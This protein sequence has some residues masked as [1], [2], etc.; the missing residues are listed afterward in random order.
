MG[1]CID[2]GVRPPYIIF[3]IQI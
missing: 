1:R 2:V 3:G